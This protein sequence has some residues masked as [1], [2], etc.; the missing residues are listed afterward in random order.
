MRIS[1][2]SDLTNLTVVGYGIVA[3]LLFALVI[4]TLAVVKQ[5]DRIRFDAG[6]GDIVIPSSLA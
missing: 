2:N 1:A 4:G 6:S 3:T 5:N